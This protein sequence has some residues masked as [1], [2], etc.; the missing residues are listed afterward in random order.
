MNRLALCAALAGALIGTAAHASEPAARRHFVTVQVT[1]YPKDGPF[2]RLR[3]AKRDTTALPDAFGYPGRPGVHVRLSDAPGSTGPKPTAADVRKA[4]ADL[5][6]DDRLGPDDE[7]IVH[8]SAI[9][10]ESPTGPVVCPSG[11]ALDDP[12]SMILVAEIA[13]RVRLIPVARKL[14]V[15]D[16]C[17]NI[18]KATVKYH[19]PAVPKADSVTRPEGLEKP[20]SFVLVQAASKGQYAYNCRNSDFGILT[21]QLVAAL[22]EAEAT[23]DGGITTSAIR[24]FLLLT[25]PK[26]SREA[27]QA[28][29]VPHVSDDSSA[30][31]VLARV[32]KPAPEPPQP[33]KGEGIAGA[34]PKPPGGT[35]GASGASGNTSWYTPPQPKPP[36]YQAP[37][38][39]PDR[40]DRPVLKAAATQALRYGLS[41]IR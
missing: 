22:R 33:P 30:V 29:Q 40:P 20:T 11:A 24:D 32:T 23:K 1:E 14:I 2:A 35:G 37:A 13:Q 27:Y 36:A 4:L 26:A 19:E 12:D 34:P 5:A 16:S 38:P 28:E 18:V 10:F 21:C 8:V 9:G 3:P 41:K 15:V 39:R 25:V 7:I 6:T 17:R 31:W